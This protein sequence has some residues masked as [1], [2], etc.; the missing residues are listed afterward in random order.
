MGDIALQ[1]HSLPKPTIAA[2]NGVAA[3]AGCNLALGC[4][5]V[6]ASNT[7]RFSQIFVQRGL[8]VD[9]GGTWLLPRLIGLHKAKD[10][11]VSRRDPE[12]GGEAQDLG[13]VNRVVERDALMHVVG[14]MAARLADLAPLALSMMKRAFNESFSMS[15]EAAL[16][17]EAVAQASMFNSEDASEAM[18]AFLEKRSPVFPRRL[19]RRLLRA[20]S[21]RPPGTVPTDVARRGRPRCQ[22]RGDGRDRRHATRIR[23]HRRR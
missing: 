10:S 11:R 7:A 13:V 8:T 22:A 15:M 14:E 12:Q 4:D 21:G 19:A 9:F 6:V 1:L 3:G 20:P 5:L 16:E 17:N 2:V 23:G 18:A